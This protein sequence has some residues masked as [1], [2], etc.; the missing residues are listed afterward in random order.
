MDRPRKGG[1]EFEKPLQY[2]IFSK[3]DADVE[4]EFLY[5][6]SV[7]M[8]RGANDLISHLIAFKRHHQRF[9]DTTLTSLQQSRVTKTGIMPH[10]PRK[11]RS[12][13]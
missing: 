4:A 8:S 10:G 7:Q 12:R 11:S 3:D 1:A 6:S 9:R 2:G 13:A 5:K